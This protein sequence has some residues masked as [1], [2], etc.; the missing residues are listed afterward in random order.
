M[1]WISRERRTGR[2]EEAEV[3]MV[4][5]FASRQ[6]DRA[7]PAYG[8]YPVEQR[9]HSIEVGTTNEEAYV[10]AVT[11]RQPAVLAPEDAGAD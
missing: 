1:Y 10:F 9:R 8:H 7:R 3:E 4:K 11:N 6:D 5:V 2:D